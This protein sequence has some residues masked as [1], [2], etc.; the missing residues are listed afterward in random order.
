VIS[1]QQRRSTTDTARNAETSRSVCINPADSDGIVRLCE[2]CVGF[3][4]FTER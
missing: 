1:T 4:P 2:L 3:G